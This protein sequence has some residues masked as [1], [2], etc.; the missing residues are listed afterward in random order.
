MNENT[1][2]VA[3]GTAVKQQ[4]R[5]PRSFSLV[6]YATAEVYVD[7][8]FATMEQ[9]KLRNSSGSFAIL[10]AIRCASSLLSNFAAAC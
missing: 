6:S 2:S 3:K 8:A 10:T 4:R 9:N 7:D 1:P 5:Q